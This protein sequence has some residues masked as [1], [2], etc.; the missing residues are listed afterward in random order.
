MSIKNKTGESH[1]KQSGSSRSSPLL[2]TCPHFC[3]KGHEITL[4]NK[5]GIALAVCR[6][7]KK[8]WNISMSSGYQICPK[9][10]KV[11]KTMDK[12]GR[13]VMGPLAY[14]GRFECKR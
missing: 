3:P 2:Y 14:C 5:G 8:S 10:K 1:A 9:C 4:E 12:I 13:P 11:T 6:I 7:C